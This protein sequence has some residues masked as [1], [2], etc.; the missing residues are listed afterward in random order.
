MP[1]TTAEQNAR[2]YCEAIG[3]DP[4]EIVSGYQSV[5]FG[6]VWIERPRWLWYIGAELD[7]TVTPPSR[8]KLPALPGPNIMDN[9]RRLRPVDGDSA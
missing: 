5:A 6:A 9:L 4:E 8:P 3:A 1:R 2:A 7:A